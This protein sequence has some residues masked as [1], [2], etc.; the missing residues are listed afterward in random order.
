[1]A[2]VKLEGFSAGLRGKALEAQAGYMLDMR[3]GELP[4]GL[5]RLIVCGPEM[6]GS[7]TVSGTFCSYFCPQA[8]ACCATDC[9]RLINQVTN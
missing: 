7:L 1:M 2:L 5:F 9:R 3:W 6:T 4:A 8:L